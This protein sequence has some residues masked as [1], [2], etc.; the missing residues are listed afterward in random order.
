MKFT[1]QPSENLD[2]DF[3]FTKWMPVGDNLPA[4]L[5]NSVVTISPS[6]GIVL[7]TK[8]HN[9]NIVKQFISGGTSGT[10]YLVTCVITTSDGR[11][12]EAEFTLRVFNIGE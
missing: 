11:I 6:S 1:K 4:T 8:L 5:G 2:Y 9:G 12:K 7:G 3:D 10:D